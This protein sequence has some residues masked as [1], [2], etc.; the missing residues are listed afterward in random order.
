MARVL[1]RELGI[2]LKQSV[3]ID[4][5][6]G[7]GG[8]IG[9]S[10]VA[11]AAPDGYTLFVGDVALIT[12]PYLMKK[13]PYNWAEDFDPISGLSAAPLVLTVPVASPIKTL[14]QL[15]EQGKKSSTGLTFSS[16]GIGSTPHL[17]GELLKIRSKSLLTHVPYKGS[18]PAMLD[19]IAGRLDFAFSTIAAAR[20]FI[21]QEKLRVLATT[22]TERST[23]FQ[24]FQTVAETVPD[25]KVIFWTG[26]LAPSK[27]PSDILEKL[28]DAV[29]QSLVSD[30]IQDELK[31]TG[32]STNY[33][34]IKQSKDFFADES[35]RWGSIISEAKIQMD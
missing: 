27:T 1:A 22:G 30:L 15:I 4:N 33:L 35:K 6:P 13:V 17:A 2:I 20:P 31:K 28:N 5:K 32:E 12:T 24:E 23:A 21:A 34:S 3:I 11:H 10:Y 29:R 14:A 8:A 26:L 19:L 18:G 25:F 7:A 9:A 16:A